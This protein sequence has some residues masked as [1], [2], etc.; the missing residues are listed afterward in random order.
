M[1]LELLGDDVVGRRR[2]RLQALVELSRGAAASAARAP[3]RLK[4]AT[5]QHEQ[6]PSTTRSAGRAGSICHRGYMS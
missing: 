3:R 6:Q 2:N 4:T 1:L 5:V